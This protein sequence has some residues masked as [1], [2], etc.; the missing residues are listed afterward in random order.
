MSGIVKCFPTESR[1]PKQERA[2]LSEPPIT[3][4]DTEEQPLDPERPIID[5]HL[6]HWE[7]R[8]IPGLTQRFL[9]HESLDTVERSGHNISHT[10][11]VECRAMYRLDGPPEFAP[12]GETEFANGIAAMSASGGYGPCR[13]AHRIVG[14]ADLMLG[15]AVAPVIE[16]HVAAAG[17]RF[18]GVRVPTAFCE[19]G[20]FGAPCDPSLRGLMLKPA[21]RA[22]ASVLAGMDLSLD[23]WCLHTQ[24]DELIDLADALPTLTIVLNHVGTPECHGG[25]TGREAQ[26]RAEWAAKIV[27]LARRPNVYVKLG[28]MGMRIDGQIDGATGPATSETLAANWRSRIETCIE[29][30]TAERCMFESNFP[31][32]GASGSYGATWNAFKR[33]T[34]DYSEDEKDWLFRKTAA[35]VYRIA[36]ESGEAE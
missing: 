6:H 36:L 1:K 8:P 12:L 19:A 25:Y 27:E 29:A 9:L 10:V 26:A 23:V 16:A 13:L 11:F 7:I 33:V 34:R 14:N 30:F 21:F 35:R 3:N 18:R 2:T 24:L 32:D 4:S 20:L 22:G 5:S 15:A 17:E 28:G 31:P